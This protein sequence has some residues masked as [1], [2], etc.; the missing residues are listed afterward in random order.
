MMNNVR[1]GNGLSRKRSIPTAPIIPINQAEDCFWSKAS[2]TTLASRGSI[3]AVTGKNGRTAILQ[4]IQP[5]ATTIPAIPV[6]I[7][8]AKDV[9]RSVG[10]QRRTSI[11]QSELTDR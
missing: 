1:S 3:I 7:L 4:A 2:T 8:I 10:E 5:I 9:R 11:D 6:E